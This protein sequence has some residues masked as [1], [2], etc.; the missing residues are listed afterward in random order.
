MKVI[1]AK[2]L[3][4]FLIYCVTSCHS[5]KLVA[6]PFQGATNPGEMKIWVLVKKQGEV[7]LILI[8]KQTQARTSIT[9]ATGKGTYR[10]YF[11]LTFDF[12]NLDNAGLY[13]WEFITAKD[14]IRGKTEF[15]IVN[16]SISD[17]SFLIGSCV[18]RI[19]KPFTL[20]HPGNEDKIFDAMRGKEC[21]FMLWLGDNLYYKSK[22]MA[23]SYESM[24]IQYV[25]QRKI[26]RLNEFL[27]SQAN[28]AIWDDHDFGTNDSNR[29]FKYKEF[30]L[31]V[32]KNYWPNPSYGLS[33][34]PGVFFHFVKK[35]VEFF[36]TDGRYHRS[37]KDVKD[38]TYF[39]TIQK[40][41]LKSKLLASKATFKFIATG[42]QVFSPV[43]KGESF[44]DF[45]TELNDLVSFIGENKI[46]GVIFLSGDRHHT[47]LMK[48]DD[49]I[50]YP[51]YEFTNSALTSIGIRPKNS[52]EK[53]N[54]IRIENTMVFDNNFGR[55]SIL[56][57]LGDRSCK[58]ET[59]SN[60]GK[61]LWEYIIPQ[62]ELSFK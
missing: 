10:K 19:P 60:T 8:N 59:F 4:I 46:S 36:M 47:E 48:V 61:L 38:A 49:K 32:F 15:V 42:N 34:A 56:G 55:I 14:T 45:K 27:M 21:E 53:T 57:P 1:R 22:Q 35:D 28:Y 12:K 24:E 20:L 26:R 44:Q 7:K 51:I 25:K 39:G 13:S 29:N 30:S 17:F 16:D 11:P 31:E 41:W 9:Q 33:E 18:V 2:F 52:T 50:E 43:N 40:E 6:G 58:L 54:P 3:F 23:D 62:S 5:Q 37:K